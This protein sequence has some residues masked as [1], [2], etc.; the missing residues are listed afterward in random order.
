MAQTRSFWLGK[1]L[2]WIINY[3]NYLLS[4]G[5]RQTQQLV[6]STSILLMRFS[7]MKAFVRDEI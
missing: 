6:N 4:K 1:F 5:E 7:K 2:K 3:L